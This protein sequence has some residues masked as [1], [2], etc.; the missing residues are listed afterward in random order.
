VATA[1]LFAMSGDGKDD[2]SI[3]LVF[4]FRREYDTL[5][6]AMDNVQD[7][8]VFVGLTQKKDGGSKTGESLHVYRQCVIGNNWGGYWEGVV[9][10]LSQIHTLN[11]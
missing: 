8:R 7:L 1:P 4:V 10:F 5:Q 9:E 3:P 6:R 2:V 11:R